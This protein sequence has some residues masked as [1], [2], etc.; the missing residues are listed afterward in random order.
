MCPCTR[1]PR[2]LFSYTCYRIRFLSAIWTTSKLLP[3]FIPLSFYFSWYLA[4]LFLLPFVL[5]KYFS[6]SLFHGQFLSFF[7]VFI[8][9]QRERSFEWN[10][11]LFYLN[12][13]LEFLSSLKRPTDI[14]SVWKE[15]WLLVIVAHFLFNSLIWFFENLFIYREHL[16]ARART[17]HTHTH[18]ES[19]NNPSNS[20]FE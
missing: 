5:A 14:R 20:P 8:S 12:Q 17:T 11:S 4:F 15:C 9:F 2:Q 6:M 18:T 13:Y 3:E 7:F 10:M 19:I 1:T 16:C